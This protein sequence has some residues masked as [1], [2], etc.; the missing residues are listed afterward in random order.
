MWPAPLITSTRRPLVALAGTLCFS[1]TVKE[2]R[3]GA[4]IN[5]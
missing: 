2:P 3:I 5:R 1:C 4:W